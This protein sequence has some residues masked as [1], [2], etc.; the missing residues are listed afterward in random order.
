MF[1]ILIKKNIVRP[2]SFQLI[3]EFKRA[4]VP[5]DFDVEL[6]KNKKNKNDNEQIKKEDNYDIEAKKWVIKD[7]DEFRKLNERED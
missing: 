7:S 6:L 4:I 5:S 1:N 2:F 3:R